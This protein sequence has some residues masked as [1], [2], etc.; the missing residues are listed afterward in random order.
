MSICLPVC[1]FVRSFPE[2]RLGERHW[3]ITV[4]PNTTQ[5]LVLRSQNSRGEAG[6][7]MNTEG[8]YSVHVDVSISDGESC[9]VWT[10]GAVGTAQGSRRL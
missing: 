5:A 8:C 2:Y 6:R 4:K 1:P 10:E 3:L 7:H 9:P